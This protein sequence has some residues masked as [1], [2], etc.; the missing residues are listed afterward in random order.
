M[1]MVGGECL[2]CAVTSEPAAKLQVQIKKALASAGTLD[3]IGL[4]RSR[5][6]RSWG[7]LRYLVLLYLLLKLPLD[8][9]HLVFQ[10]ELQLLQPSFL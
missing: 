9:L 4:S 10:A 2:D 5:P 6:R 3:I 8:T 1:G 7:S